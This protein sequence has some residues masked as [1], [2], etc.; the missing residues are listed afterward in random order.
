MAGEVATPATGDTS[1]AIGQGS[2]LNATPAQNGTEAAK[3][4]SGRKTAGTCAVQKVPKAPGA[5]AIE[6]ARTSNA[7]PHS[8]CVRQVAHVFHAFS[9]RGRHNASS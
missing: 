8:G 2:E 4:G 5:I 7:T 1:S 6:I 9:V 3:C